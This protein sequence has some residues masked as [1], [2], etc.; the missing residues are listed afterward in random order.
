[1]QISF[2]EVN[3]NSRTHSTRTALVLD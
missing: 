1:M 3:L 2:D